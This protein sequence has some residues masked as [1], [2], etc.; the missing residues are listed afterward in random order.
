[1]EFLE[2][3]G[4]KL[5]SSYDRLDITAG[6]DAGGLVEVPERHRDR[7]RTCTVSDGRHDGFVV[8]GTVRLRTIPPRP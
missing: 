1:M 6:G 8:C 7:F 2:V 3:V 4:M 5:R